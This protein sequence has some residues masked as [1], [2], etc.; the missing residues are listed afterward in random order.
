MS[1]GRLQQEIVFWFRN[2]FP[3]LRGLLCYNNNNSL[4]G[5]K[6]NMNKYLGV[7]KGRADMVFYYKSRAYMI[8][9][10]TEIGY[11][12]K[13]QKKWQNIIEEQGFNYSIIRSL[14]DFKILI[15]LI[16][17]SGLK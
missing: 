5:R 17:G 2:A 14:E 1:E 4:G 7:I 3:N 10:K 12:S 15:K 13:E 6:G 16:I 8:E 11:Q 9:L